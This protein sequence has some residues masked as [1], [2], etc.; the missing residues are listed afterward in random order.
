MPERRKSASTRI[1]FSP[2]IPPSAQ[3]ERE[4]ISLWLAAEVMPSADVSPEK[5]DLGPEGELNIGPGHANA[6]ANAD[7]LSFRIM[8]AGDFRQ[9]PT[10]AASR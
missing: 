2:A 5:A 10:S 8:S 6:S 7:L 4:W 3:A 1:T 9:R